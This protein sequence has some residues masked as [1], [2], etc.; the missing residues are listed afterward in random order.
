MIEIIAKSEPKISLKQ[1]IEDGLSVWQN[2]QISFPAAS[3]CAGKNNFWRLLWL[4]VVTHDLGKAHAEFQKVLHGESNDWRSQRHELFSLPFVKAL[5]ISEQDK[6]IVLR[7]VAAHHKTYQYLSKFIA[8]NYGN[9]P[10]EFEEEFSKM[11]MDGAIQIAHSFEDGL[12]SMSILAESPEKV[13][14]GYEREKRHVTTGQQKEITD[15]FVLLLLM[16]AFHHCDHLSSAF[17]TDFDVLKEQSFQFL[18]RMEKDLTRKGFGL[19]YHQGAASKLQGNVIL[20]APTGSGKTETSMLWL[21]NQLSLQQGRVFYVLPFT[22]SINAMFERLRD[23]EKGLGKDMVGMLHG[24][25]NAYLYES[26]FEDAGNLKELKTQIKGLKQTFKNLQT[27][28]KVIT[29]FQLLKHLFGLKGF[30]KGI[31]EWAG[32]HFIFDEIHAYDPEVTAQIIVLLEYL[33]NR[34]QAKIFIMTATLPSFL[35]KRIG[36]AIGTFEEIKAEPTLYEN[37]KRHRIKLQDGLLVESLN[38]IREDLKA[39]KS[40][41][42]VCNTVDYAR[43]VYENLHSDYD[44]LLIHGRFVAKDRTIIERR[45]QKKPPQLLIGTQAIEVS[46]DIDYDTI[47]TEPAPLD[48]LIQRFGRVNRK[49]L[50]TPCPCIVFKERNEKDKYIY[51]DALVQTTLEVL[52]EIERQNEGVIQEAELQGYIDRVY[53]GYD[54]EAQRKFDNIY[55]LLTMSAK[56]LTPFMPSQEGEDDYY[57]QFDGIKVLPAFYEQEFKRLLDQFDFIGAEQLK[58][59]IRKN[60][61]ARLIN[62]SGLE[63]KLHV[64]VPSNNPK[65]KPIDISYYRINKWYRPDT[66]LDFEKDEET[67]FVINSSE[68]IF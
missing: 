41:L 60:W 3:D 62:D 33:T 65:I 38:M 5:S 8:D 24:N 47:Y 40:V 12:I 39:E 64:I 68:I 36:Q 50:K 26:F 34:L 42:V 43:H 20:T 44:S 35:K 66:G 49:R 56:R 27:P 18:D 37:F 54:D 48:A 4:S 11:N 31:F 29:P 19:Y 53:P 21:R 7:V 57:R 16:G 10:T 1:H 15:Y 67:E 52:D 6:I 61:F 32:G 22:A 58:V 17:V 55:E 51:S 63:R 45:L 59:S 46:L 14:Y 2:L 23:D 13:I 9:D 30:E 25:L 28:L